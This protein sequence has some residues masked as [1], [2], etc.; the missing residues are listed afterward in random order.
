M[1]QYNHHEQKRARAFT[2]VELLL[3]IAIVGLILGLIL[4]AVQAARSTAR[5]L[6]CSNSMRQIGLA[7]HLYH[8]VTGKFP[9]SKWGIENASDKY[10]RVKHHVL[11]FILPY[12]EAQALYSQI[13]FSRDWSDPANDAATQ[14]HL[15]MYHCPASPRR[16][17]YG[18]QQY[19][20]SDYAVAE[21]IQKS[22]DKIKPLFDSG[23]VSP[24]KNLHG[25][26]QP[27]LVPVYEG[28]TVIH[29]MMSRTVTMVSVKDGLSNT[30]L[31]EECAARPFRYGQYRR[32]I[33]V[34]PQARPL[35]GADWASNLSPFYILE[36]CGG[37]NMQLF[38]CTNN[39][40]IYAFHVGGANFVFGDNAVRFLTEII[41][42]EVF[43]S[44]FTAAAG[45]PN[46]MP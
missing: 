8:E 33:A 21:E 42:P 31:F 17:H 44:L 41:H 27:P 19:F 37:D 46:L 36:S 9:A 26:L 28:A 13:D 3:V 18:N 12:M 15:P 7:L 1:F 25:I 30:M 5:R 39:N 10:K 4:P 34:S 38:N 43:I 11:S 35:T 6:H 2:L 20:V 23:T 16:D 24:R 14:V 45:D 32:E 40:E 29:N 22:R